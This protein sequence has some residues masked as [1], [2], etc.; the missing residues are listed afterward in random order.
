MKNP[1]ISVIMSVYNGA[2]YLQECIQSILNQSF[3]NFE[4]IVIN[5]CSTDTSPTI[6]NECARKDSR[7]VIIDN[8]VN[9]GLTKSL[10]VGLKI[11]KGKYI[12]RIDS[13]DIALPE[14]LQT[15]YD[16]L[17]KNKDLFLVGSG[18]YT[19]D[20]NGNIRTRIKV[21]TD[22][23]DIKNKLAIQNCISHPTIM[24]RN[25]G[26]V[27]REKFVYSQ[28]YDFYLTLLSN[29]KKISN[30]FEPLI[31][32]RINP[33][34]ISWSKKSKQEYFALKANELYHQRR[35]YGKDEYDTFDSDAILS[36][37]VE[38]ATDKLTLK[39]EI[40]ARFK[41][42]EFKEVRVFCGKYFGN[43][44]FFNSVTIYYI[45]SFTGENFIN[46]LRKI[47]YR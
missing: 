31:K 29:N 44:G 2:E 19:I 24:F 6:I 11:A 39:T 27:Y 7:I 13:D 25:E 3:R 28:D 22:T 30:I 10:N 5:D 14:R 46:A 12:A 37:D 42:N 18:S 1:Q 23:E 40:E 33:N 45:L 21:L 35:R 43:Y 34:A 38:N 47:I 20:T 15:Q 9:I 32:Y 26:F 41:L 36:M 16:F 4:F 8:K 17:E